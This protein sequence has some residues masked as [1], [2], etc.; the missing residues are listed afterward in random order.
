MT[1]GRVVK[2]THC[3]RLVSHSNVLI[4][5]TRM[6]VRNNEAGGHFGGADLCATK[7]AVEIRAQVPRDGGQVLQ[8]GLGVCNERSIEVSINTVNTF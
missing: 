2:T 3:C 5:K 6:M 7:L 1:N 4:G 8:H